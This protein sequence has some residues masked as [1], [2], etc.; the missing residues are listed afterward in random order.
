[1]EGLR[2][3]SNPLK[4]RREFVDFMVL[5]SNPALELGSFLFNFFA[6]GVGRGCLIGTWHERGSPEYEKMLPEEERLA[7]SR[8]VIVVKVHK[9]GS[10]SVSLLCS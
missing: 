4:A 5:V 10:V 6:D 1:M 8:S 3:C 9:V 2:S 7:G